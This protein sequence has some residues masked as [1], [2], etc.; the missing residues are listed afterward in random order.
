MLEHEEENNLNLFLGVF[1]II[2]LVSRLLFTFL[3]RYWY[4]LE[5]KYG[6]QFFDVSC[7]DVQKVN[8]DA[9]DIGLHILK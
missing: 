9:G 5:S 2:F 4:I 7:C 8:F 3:S 1:I 6:E